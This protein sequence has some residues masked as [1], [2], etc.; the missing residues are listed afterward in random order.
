MLDPIWKNFGYGKLWPVVVS[1]Y[2]QWRSAPCQSLS[3]V[4]LGSSSVIIN[5]GAQLLVSDYQQWCSAPRQWLSTVVLGSSSVIINSGARLLVSDYQQWRSA[6]RQWL[7]TVALGSSSVIINSGARLL[8][9]DYPRWRSAPRQWLSIVVL[10]SSSAI[11]NSGAQLLVSDYQQWRLVPHQWLSVV[12]LDHLAQFWQNTTGWLPVSYFYTQQHTFTD[13]LNHAVQNQP[14]SDLVL[15]DC[16][17]IWPNRPG[18]EAS[19]F[20]T[21]IRPASGQHFWA[22]P[23]WASKL[24]PI[25]CETDQACLLGY[26][27][28]IT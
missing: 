2:R 1:D 22:A 7:S 5:S 21:V 23:D 12:A 9:S 19:W 24:I 25:G 15:T 26:W 14:R 20:A 13:C 18:Q 8:V 6:P 28:L 10:G 16:V 17:R 27:T 3:L 4:A 11:I